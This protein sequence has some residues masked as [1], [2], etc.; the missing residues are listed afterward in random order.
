M[1]PSQYRNGADWR[2]Q[3]TTQ[4]EIPLLACGQ[5]MEALLAGRKTMTRRRVKLPESIGEDYSPACWE[6]AK[7]P[8]YA[9]PGE[10]AFID[11]AH[12]TDS[13]PWLVTCPYRAG[14]IIWWRETWRVARI[15]GAMGDPTAEFA[16]IQFR[17]GW[18]VLPYMAN[19]REQYADLLGREPSWEKSELGN[20]YGRWHPSIHMPKWACR[21]RSE[22]VEVLPPQRVQGISEE[23]MLAEGIRLPPTELYP[24]INTEDKLKQ[25]L[26]WLW[27]SLH[28]PESWTRNPFVWPIRFRNLKETERD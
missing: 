5:M 11:M 19:W 13:Y 14:D 4:H 3:M 20:L 1:T 10:V 28:G 9:K 22:I 21:L 25:R 8:E 15:N 17:E 16:T 12:P 24:D 6:L 26:K 27:S 7:T 18:G 23:D 2:M